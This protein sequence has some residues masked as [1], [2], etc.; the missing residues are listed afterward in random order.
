M[1]Y[2]LLK[3]FWETSDTIDS[4]SFQRASFICP[5]PDDLADAARWNP[6]N[7]HGQS[8]GPS[9]AAGAGFFLERMRTNPP[10]SPQLHFGLI[11]RSKFFTTL[12]DLPFIGR[13]MFN[14]FGCR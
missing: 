13:T 1:K 10:G 3:N 11:V 8:I 9:L 4:E 7:Q 14:D 2:G 6:S 12:T 5:V